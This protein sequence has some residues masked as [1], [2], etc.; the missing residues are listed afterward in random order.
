MRQEGYGGT[1]TTM[2]VAEEAA[3]RELLG[4]PEHY[5]V[6]AVVPLGTPVHQ[7]TRLKRRRV[8]EFVTSERFDGPTFSLG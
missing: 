8:E 2:V 7:P 5:A 6:A 3:V 4:C 1:I